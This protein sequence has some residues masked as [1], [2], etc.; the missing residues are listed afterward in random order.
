MEVGGLFAVFPRGT[1]LFAETPD[2]FYSLC[3]CGG[4]ETEIRAEAPRALEE[5][6]SEGD[7]PAVRRCGGSA[8]PS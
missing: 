7:I 3:L 1:Y 6:E 8:D 4:R 5:R 2:L